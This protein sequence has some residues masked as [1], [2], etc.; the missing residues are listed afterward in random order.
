MTIERN[1]LIGRYV[2]GDLSEREAS[3][4]ARH[5]ADDR[6]WR[7]EYETLQQLRS[8]VRTL[9]E[10]DEPPAALDDLMTP[11]RRDGRPAPGGFGLLPLFAAAAAVLLWVVVGSTVGERV[12]RHEMPE[13]GGTSLMQDLPPTVRTAPV[14]ALDRLMLWAIPEPDLVLPEALQILGPLPEPP[15]VYLERPAAGR[16]DGEHRP[17]AVP[18]G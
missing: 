5:I 7:E 9:A 14:G 3:A 18:T 10:R 13:V 15:G 2:D 12:W 16:E 4:V 11:L 8:T 1:E 17:D 6:A